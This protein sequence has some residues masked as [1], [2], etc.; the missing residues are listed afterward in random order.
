MAATALA[1]SGAVLLAGSLLTAR[2]P[3]APV[4]DFD[5]YLELWRPL[6]GGY[7]ARRNPWLLGWLRLAHLVGRPLARRGVQPDLLTV[8][9]AWLGAAVVVAALAGG[10]WPLLGVVLIVVSG[11]TDTVDGCV[12][13]LTRRATAWGHVLDSMVDRVADLLYVLALVALGATAWLA[14]T[15]AAAFF[16]LE[17][18]R[19]RAEAGGMR[20][21]EKVTL[22][23]RANRVILPAFGLLGAG[24]AA[25]QAALAGN[26]A[27]TALA[28]LSTIGLVQ[29]LVE[30]RRRLRSRP[31]SG[32]EGSRRPSTAQEDP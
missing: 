31:G 29:L 5:A 21:I 18:L 11:L 16:L 8:W 7:D 3:T 15:T 19:A 13:V 20:G 4:A 17:Y 10:R 14:A 24:L 22:G 32:G 6:H 2:P 12:A 1:L 28:G 25:G 27:L 30:V 26:V 9:G 23:E